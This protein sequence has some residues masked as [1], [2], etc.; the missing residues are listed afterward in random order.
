MNFESPQNALHHSCRIA[1]AWKK[2]WVSLRQECRE[3]RE[4][5]SANTLGAKSPHFETKLY[6]SVEALRHR[7]AEAFHSPHAISQAGMEVAFKNP[8]RRKQE[9]K[10]TGQKEKRS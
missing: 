2:L 4:I 5:I 3:V 6:R 8:R 7:Q 1:V 9:G 10:T